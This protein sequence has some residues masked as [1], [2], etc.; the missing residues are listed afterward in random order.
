MIFD[1]MI[2]CVIVMLFMFFCNG[3]YLLR[4]L[5]EIYVLFIDMFLIDIVFIY[6]FNVVYI[7]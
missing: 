2:I 1:Y 4:F 7:M 6:Y 5:K 3:V